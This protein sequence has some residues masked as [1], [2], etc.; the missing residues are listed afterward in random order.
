M[1]GDGMCEGGAE[2]EGG[3]SGAASDREGNRPD[4]AQQ[5]RAVRGGPQLHGLVLARGM[6]AW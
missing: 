4:P 6:V 1:T 5:Q 2:P 3:D